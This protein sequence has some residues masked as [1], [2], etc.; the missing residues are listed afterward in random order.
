MLAKTLGIQKLVIL[1]NKM[2]EAT[3]QWR[4]ERFDEIE[5]KLTPFLKKWGYNVAKDVVFLPASGY[6]GH[7]LKDKVPASVCDWYKG[8]SLF[9]TFDNLDAVKRNATGPF[10]MPIMSRYKDMG[11]ICCLYVVQRHAT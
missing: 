1:V 10:R 4:K 9:D 5:T 8:K 11:Q 6:T 2:D 7:N 3:V